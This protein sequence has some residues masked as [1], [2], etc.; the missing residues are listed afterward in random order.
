[1]V[2]DVGAVLGAEP[3]GEL[4]AGVGLDLRPAADVDVAVG[5][6]EVEQ[7]EAALGLG[8]QVLDLEARGVERGLQLTLVVEEPDLGQLRAAGTADRG[9][10]RDLRVEQ[11]AMGS[12]RS[13]DAIT[14]LLSGRSPR[15]RSPSPLGGELVDLG[16]LLGGEVEVV[17]RGDVLLQLARP[18]RRRSPARSRAGRA[19]P[20]RAPA[21]A[22]DWPRRAAMSLSS[23]SRPIISSL[24]QSLSKAPWSSASPASPPGRRRG[25]GR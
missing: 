17:E 21:A 5:V 14:T 22:S 12:G 9:Q 20:R 7:E 11:V 15:G 23:R 2:A 13:N 16:Q 19:A 18:R 25:S 3:G 6:G 10:G 24:S 8:L 4:V 1:M